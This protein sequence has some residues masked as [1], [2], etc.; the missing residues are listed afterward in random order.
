MVPEEQQEVPMQEQ[1]GSMA[2]RHR[3][4]G[5]YSDD[6]DSGNDG[7]AS[8]S[9]NHPSMR[10]GLLLRRSVHDAQSWSQTLSKDD[11]MDALV[12]REVDTWRN[13]ITSSTAQDLRHRHSV[14]GHALDEVRALVPGL[15][16]NALIISNSSLSKLSLTSRY[17]PA[18]LMCCLTLHLLPQ[19]L[20]VTQVDSLLNLG[21]LLLVQPEWNLPVRLRVHLRPLRP[22]TDLMEARQLLS[23]KE[24]CPRERLNRTLPP[25]HSLLPHHSVSSPLHHPSFNNLIDLHTRST[26]L[27][28]PNHTHKIWTTN[29][30]L[31]SSR[32]PR[33][34][35][36]HHSQWPTSAPTPLL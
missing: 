17:R 31:N 2:G 23:S 7:P 10:G 20:S 25:L 30:D 15:L 34:D 19:L 13:E 3:T 18:V 26:S 33:R 14:S 21:P 12:A 9:G 11:E 24:L 27:L 22:G 4:T 28:C 5:K 32:R 35:R 16:S 36:D 6:E 8:S 29:M 1:R